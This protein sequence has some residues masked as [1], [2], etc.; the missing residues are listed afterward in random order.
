MIFVTYSYIFKNI[1]GINMNTPKVTKG[2]LNLVFLT[3]FAFLFN[4]TVLLPVYT[5]GQNSTVDNSKFISHSI[6]D[7]MTAGETYNVVVTYEN[8]G[9]TIWNAGEY[10]LRV[11]GTGN[12]TYTGTN[13]WGVSDQSLTSHI[14]PGKTLT[15]ELKLIAPTAEGSYTFQTEL[16]RGNNKFGESS[17]LVSVSVGS[18][19][20]T[21]Y[22]LSSAAFVEQTV[23]DKMDAGKNY[24]VM[25]T[26]TNTGKTTWTPGLYRLSFLDPDGTGTTD[27]KWGMNS[28]EITENIA[29]GATKVFVFDVTAPEAGNYT[30]QW[31]MS[32]SQTG[33]F[34]DATKIA[35]IEVTPS[36]DETKD[37]GKDA[38][39]KFR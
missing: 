2:K 6:P 28:V 25:I 7:N 3:L 33:L 35:V 21:G 26:M 37:E 39:K 19:S 30:L 5:Q 38:D 22:L 17:Q 11:L 13:V 4:I 27:K 18:G 16:I 23:Q 34:G 1:T 36:R 24:K 31:R 12:N 9:T 20:G 14:E 15:F 29:P 10:K 8:S 32:G